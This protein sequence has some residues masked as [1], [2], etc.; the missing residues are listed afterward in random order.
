MPGSPVAL[1]IIDATVKPPVFFFSG[2]DYNLSAAF[3]THNSFQLRNKGGRIFTLRK[4]RT[5][6]KLAEPANADY[7][8]AIFT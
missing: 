4:L 2:L 5:G 6:N 1:G 3:W 7:L 8:L